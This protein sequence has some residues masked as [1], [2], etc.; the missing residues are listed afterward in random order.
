MLVAFMD[1]VSNVETF[2]EREAV[3]PGE[4]HHVLHSPAPSLLLGTHRLVFGQRFESQRDNLPP[5]TES[6]LR[7]VAARSDAHC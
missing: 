3:F 5:Q 1:Q 7:G 6:G 2:S 4:L